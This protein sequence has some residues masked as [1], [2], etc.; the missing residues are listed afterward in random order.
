MVPLKG[1]SYPNHEGRA[2]YNPA[3]VK[4][5]VKG[6]KAAID[7]AIP[8]RLLPL[9]VNDEAFGRAVVEV[10]EDLLRTT[11]VGDVKND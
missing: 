1:F 4:A 9:H 11:G 3:G 8:V 7:P 5:F 10:F 6:L 2:F